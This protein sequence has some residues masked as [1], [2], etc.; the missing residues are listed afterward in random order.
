[1]ILQQLPDK[2]ITACG[3]TTATAIVLTVF[4]L[5]LLSQIEGFVGLPMCNSL[6]YLMKKHNKRQLYDCDVFIAISNNK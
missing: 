5:M 6:R 3:H 2:G 1:M 4:L